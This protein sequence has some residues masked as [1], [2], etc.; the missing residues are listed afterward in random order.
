MKK[1]EGAGERARGRASKKRNGRTVSP[2]L[3]AAAFLVGVVLLLSGTVGGA[4][5]ALTYY[6]ENYTSRV[7]MYDIG[8][9]LIENEQ[10]VAWRDFDGEAGEWDEKRGVLLEDLLREDEVLRLGKAYQEELKVRNTGSIGQYVRVTI[11]RYWIDCDPASHPEG[12]DPRTVHTEEGERRRD[13]DPGYIE[14]HLLEG[15]GWLVDHAS[16]TP[17]RTVL[18]YDTVLEAGAETTLFADTLTISGQI[19]AKVTQ[20]V[21]SRTEGGRTY[22]TVTSTYDYNGVEFR[23]EAKVDAVQEHN[24]EAAI[25]SAWGR[26]VTVTDGRLSLAGE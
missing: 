5:A 11:Y 6:S 4:R 26:N 22:T 7:R 16:S 14:L 19:A 2:V 1:P 8:V 23:V 15:N 13:L 21:S 10:V 25:G 9:T 3:T 24:A 20:E 18:Y 17:E 12:I